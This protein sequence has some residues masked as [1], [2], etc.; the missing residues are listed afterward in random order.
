MRRFGG[1]ARF[2]AAAACLALVAAA[3]GGSDDDGGGTAQPGGQTGG[4]GRQGG[5]FRV[6]IGEPS[7]IDPYNARESEGSNVTV[8]L[9]TGLVTYDGNPELRMRPGVAERWASNNDCT[10][11]TFNLRRGSKFTNGED[12]DASAFI[13]GWTR[14]AVGTSASQVAYHLQDVQGYAELHANPPQT[15]TFSGL[16]APDPYTLVVRLGRSDC[17]FD[18]QTVHPVASPVP[19][20]AG[21]ANNTTFNEAPIGNGPFMLRPGTKWEHNQRIS[22]VRND[23][24]FGT[25]PNIDA[26]EFVIFPAQGRLEA[27]YRAFQAGEVDFARIP[28]TLTQQAQSTYQPQGSW[29]KSEQPAINY[30]LTNNARAPFNNPDARKAMSMA[31]DREAIN[32]GVFQGSFTPAT[33]FITPPFGNFHQ[34]GVCGDWCK[35]DVNRAKDLATRSGLTPGTRIKL[36]Y[37]NDGGHEPLVQAWKDQLERNLGLVVELDGVPFA[38]H[39]QKRDRGDFDIARAAWSTDYPSP[40]GFVTP[41]LGSTSEDNDGKYSNPEVDRLLAQ[42]K[43]QKSDAERERII[44]E[45]ERIAI[46]RDLALSPTFYRTAYRVFDSSKWTGLGLDFF[47]RPTLETVSQKS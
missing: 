28:P 29:I 39:L 34:P 3:C 5:T 2:A 32:R 1:K 17:E 20:V 23:G 46:G 7:A 10:E 36:A 13:R 42:S 8:R 11:W 37:N 26:I 9:F 38:E 44:K 16:S 4:G 43:S 6:P 31:I 19:S 15:Q 45:I 25:K 40:D 18:K 22:L 47:E 33:A 35:H 12:V 24:Y 30:I 14:A 21:A 27:E 41:L